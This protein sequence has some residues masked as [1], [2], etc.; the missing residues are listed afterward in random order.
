MKR[1]LS[2]W[3][4]AML[5]GALTTLA[6]LAAPSWWADRG[7]VLPG[8][9]TN[10]FS[11]INLGQLKN[12][13][14][15]AYEELQSSLAA[16][17]GAGGAVSN[18]VN[19][20]SNENNY[21]AAN[22]GQLKTVAQ[23]FYDRLIE[24]GMVTNVPWTSALGDD[25]DFSVANIGQMKN[26]FSFDFAADADGDGLSNGEEINDI[27][28]DPLDADTDDDGL[29]DGDEANEFGSNP[30]VADPWPEIVILWPQDGQE[31]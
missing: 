10:D 30:L 18:L 5:C 25:S 22:I 27:G 6:V 19:S 16:V 8:A 28:T 7:V 31:I 17:G 26:V 11:A 9:A 14:T 4:V 13:A 1:R 3:V 24:V 29:T 15:N 23:P 20:F 21:A 12:M 2:L